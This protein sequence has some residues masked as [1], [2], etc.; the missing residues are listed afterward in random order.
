MHNLWL[1]ARNEYRRTVLRRAFLIATLSIPLAILVLVGLVVAI[2]RSGQDNRPVG[3]VDRAGVMD[4]SVQA[5]LPNAEERIQVVA[6]DDEEA[7]LAAL[8]RGQIQA[9]FIL[10]EGYPSSLGTELYTRE[11]SLESRAW[12]QFDDVVRAS[13][14]RDY[15]EEIRRRLTE[16]SQVTVYDVGSGR[17]FSE[18]GIANIILPIVASAFFF[19]ATMTASGYMLEA[20]AREKEN[21]TLEVLVTSV[22][23]AQLIAGKTLGLLGAVLTQLAAYAAALVAGVLI[24]APSVPELQ[25]LVVPWSFLSM[26][27]LLFLPAYL[28]FATIMVAIGSAVT[29]IQQGQQIAGILNL[30]FMAPL[31]VLPLLLENSTHPLIVGFSL[32][33]ITSFLT[34][35]LR[36]GLGT[37][38][39]WQVALG[40]GLLAASAGGMVWVATRVFRAGMLVYGQPLSAKAVWAALRG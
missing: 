24:A 28:L 9:F 32:F 40:W 15:P 6:F 21:R 27:L 38:P 25:Q 31:F 19:I 18:S 7:A 12:G 37:V 16:G 17:Q 33:P 20:V 1:V 39:T 34:L 22:T 23:P 26:V 3:Y 4:E 8:Q 2:E 14:I 11:G 30:L 36:W 13:L 5:T 35:S 10:P 29:E